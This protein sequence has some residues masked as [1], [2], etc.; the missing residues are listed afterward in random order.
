METKNKCDVALGTTP[1]IRLPLRLQPA[2]N[3]DESRKR[4]VRCTHTGYSN[5][6]G[7]RRHGMRHYTTQSVRD[8]SCDKIPRCDTADESLGVRV[9]GVVRRKRPQ[10]L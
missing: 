2:S 3:K 9:V 8:S 7:T 10:L 4:R 6:E 5:A 1:M